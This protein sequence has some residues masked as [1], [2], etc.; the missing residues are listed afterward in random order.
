M[1]KIFI[2]KYYCSSFTFA[3]LIR[4]LI[5]VMYRKY[6]II[7]F[8]TRETFILVNEIHHTLYKYSL[9]LLV[10][11]LKIYNLIDYQTIWYI[12]KKSTSFFLVLLNKQTLLLQKFF[13]FIASLHIYFLAR[14]WEMQFFSLK[15]T[16]IAPIN[17]DGI[18]ICI[19]I[20]LHSSVF[21][22]TWPSLHTR[23]I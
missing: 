21:L 3:K 6:V 14:N 15:I 7:S 23:T 18:N 17:F 5:E 13:F 12:T 1:Q 16:S 19:L 2:F 22:N 10:K 9:N 4:I 8:L 11:N 20:K